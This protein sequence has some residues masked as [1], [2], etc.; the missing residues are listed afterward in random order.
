MLSPRAKKLEVL[1]H[2]RWAVPVQAMLYS[3]S[4]CKF[5]TLLHRVG[6][7]RQSLTDTLAWLIERGWVVRNPGYGHP[8]RPEY[9]L[10]RSGAGLG[11][12]CA[13]LMSVLKSLR[14]EDV[15]LR[16]WS[17]S[18]VMAMISGAVRFS[19]IKDAVP[20]VTARALALTLKDLQACGIVARLVT[21]DYPPAT[22]YELTARGRKLC[23]VFERN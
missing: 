15:G 23:P 10:T 6:I 8:M 16:K 18:A 14:F 1:F 20:N 2:R 5:V 9:V 17:L 22:L 13:K 12:V 4:G 7:G 19:E 21:D 3:E 11:P